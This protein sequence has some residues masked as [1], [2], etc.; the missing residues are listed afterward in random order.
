MEGLFALSIL[1]LSAPASPLS[2]PAKTTELTTRREKLLPNP[3]ARL[4]EQFHEV[5]RFKHLSART[6]EAYWGWVVRWV[7]FFQSKVHPQDLSG[8]QV[9]A[10]LTHLA[11]AEK[12]AASTQN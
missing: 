5:C 10:F 8:E 3:K 1:M 7:R 11:N 9:K 2:A 12:V 4:K 6:E